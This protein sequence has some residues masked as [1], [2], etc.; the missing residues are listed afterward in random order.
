MQLQEKQIPYPRKLSKR[1][2]PNPIIHIYLVKLTFPS[3]QNTHYICIK[4]KYHSKYL[5]ENFGIIHENIN[6]LCCR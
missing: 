6:I 2:Y 3:T 1:R 4:L 5:W